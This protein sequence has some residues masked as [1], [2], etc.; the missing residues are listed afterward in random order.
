[1]GQAKRRKQQPALYG[2]PEGSNRPPFDPQTLQ[3]IE[4]AIAGGQRLMLVGD[5]QA[6][7]LAEAAGLPWLHELPQAD[8]LPQAFAWDLQIAMDGGGPSLSPKTADF[9]AGGVVVMGP[10]VGKT[11]AGVLRAHMKPEQRKRNLETL[12]QLAGADAVAEVEQL[13]ASHLNWDR[14]YLSRDGYG[15]VKVNCS[16]GL[17]RIEAHR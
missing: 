6:R 9:M 12:E 5:S 8:P 7:P 14:S 11:L 17:M 4:L 15:V 13:L 10:G 3:Q 2:T 1:M 16:F